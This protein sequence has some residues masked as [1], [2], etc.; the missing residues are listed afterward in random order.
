MSRKNDLI[1][2]IY[3]APSVYD[4]YEPMFSTLIDQYLSRMDTQITE[5]LV[6]RNK[7]HIFF[8]KINSK[9]KRIVVAFQEAYFSS[10][11]FAKIKATDD[12]EESIELAA[13]LNDAV[14][15]YTTS[16]MK[17]LYETF[18]LSF[19]YAPILGTV[20]SRVFWDGEK[21]VIENLSIKDIRF[22][23]SARTPD[24]IRYYVHDIYLTEDDIKRYQRSGVYRRDVDPSSM[25]NDSFGEDYTIH[26]RIKLQEVYTQNAKDQWTVSTFYESS[27][28]LRQDVILEDG[29]PFIVG[30]IIPQIENPID[31]HN[32]VRVYFDSPIAAIVPLQQELNIRKNQ[33]IDAIKRQL[34][35]QMLLPTMS[36]LNPIDIERG[37]RFLRI[38]DPQNVNIL[39]AP[40]PRVAGVDMES[41]EY[42]MSENI[43][44]SAQQNGVSVGTQK[45]ATES[46]IISNEGNARLQG[47]MRSFNETYFKPIFTRVSR[48]V[49][50]Y[51]DNRF[52]AGVS[53]DI[54][55]EFV[56]NI[57]TGLGA[58]N[59]EI[60]LMG[61]EKS[62]GMFNG[63]FAMAM[64]LQDAETAKESMDASRELIKEALPLMG[65]EDTENYLK[66][67]NNERLGQSAASTGPA[68]P[69]ELS[70][71]E[72]NPAGIEQYE[73][74][75]IQPGFE[76][77]QDI[78][79]NQLYG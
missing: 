37:A 51:G 59:K 17:S 2:M 18:T 74:N 31:D 43:G 12:R 23:P 75:S 29:H 41:L 10:D 14:E 7:S 36:G 53:R 40:D 39:P 38:K 13:K 55:F 58:T 64:Q 6:K 63:L 72:D 21:P 65:I 9:T 44:I 8:P 54:D 11:K 35:P 76:Q 20:V 60:Q 4:K 62:F 48:L 56:A 3:A 61:I 27:I 78:G 34:E 42:N 57:N 66:D 68:I 79:E 49:L 28:V 25:V 15:Y 50:K 1:D 47:F 22:D 16:K 52:F 33:Q 67:K 70:G 45:T 46:S 24:D 77:Q 26:N 5:S 71:M 69:P 73:G 19:Y 32:I 30:G